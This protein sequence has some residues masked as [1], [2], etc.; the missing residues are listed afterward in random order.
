MTR[1]NIL[2]ALAA[3]A[4]QRPGL[5]F[6]NYGDVSAFRAEMRSITRDLHQ[7]RTLLAAVRWRTSIDV[8]HL[9]DAFRDAFSGRLS[10]HETPEGGCELSYCVGQYWP[11]EYRRAVCAILASA[12][13]N[14]TRENMPQPVTEPGQNEGYTLRGADKKLHVVNAGTWIRTTLRRQF[15][16]GIARRWMD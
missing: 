14:Y 16:A 1:E 13:W 8:A 15:G 12:L 5:D 9:K 10:L 11:T 6:R 4:A 2:D 7:A 3:F